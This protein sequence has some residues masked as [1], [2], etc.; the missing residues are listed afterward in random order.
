MAAEKDGQ[1]MDV[2]HYMVRDD[3]KVTEGELRRLIFKGRVGAGYHNGVYSIR[4]NE[5]NRDLLFKKPVKS[6][7]SN[8]LRLPATAEKYGWKLADNILAEY[9]ITLQGLVDAARHAGITIE[10]KELRKNHLINFSEEL[11]KALKSYP[12]GKPLL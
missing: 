10:S 9:G 12:K 6:R 4:I 7:P 3:R 1:W 11:E 2:G 8:G 5:G